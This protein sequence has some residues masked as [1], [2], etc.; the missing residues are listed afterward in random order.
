[1]TSEASK[2]AQAHADLT[3]SAQHLEDSAE[4]QVDSADRR[5]ELAADRTIL[6]AERTY[7]AWV[8]TGLAALASGIGARAL[9][10]RLVP[11]WLGLAT[12]SL[13]VLFAGFCFVAAVWRE[14]MRV[15]PV[16]PDTR[17][18]PPGLLIGVNGFLLLVCL[19]ALAG[20]WFQ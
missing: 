7:A 19:A 17:R 13:L 18:L 8:R 20:I 12:A 3:Q 2:T 14:M 5:T 6:A 10:E 15:T 16:S 11:D 9:L 4:V 1:M